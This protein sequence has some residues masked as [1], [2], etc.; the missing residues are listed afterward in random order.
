MS[1]AGIDSG[2]VRSV[3]RAL[4]LLKLI[5][6]HP[7]CG[8]HALHQ[9][10]GLP[11]P[12]VLRLLRT[13]EREGYLE[14]DGI[15][16]VYHLAAKVQELSRGYSSRALIAKIAAPIVLATTGR[17]RWPLAVGTLDDDAIVVRYSTMPYSPLAVVNTTLGH[18]H[19]LLTSAM[20]RAYLNACAT[21][22]RQRLLQ[23]L[24]ARRTPELRPELRELRRQRALGYGL[25]LARRRGESATLAVA[26]VHEREVLA[27]LSLTSFGRTMDDAFIARQLPVLQ[28]TA[29]RVVAAYRAA[30]TRETPYPPV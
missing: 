9:A 13:L 1:R 30:L 19:S 23:T 20:G 21:G 29:S 26:V 6:A 16:G 28:T 17:I 2:S 3:A 25:R 14:A 24:N 7:G 5:N 4:A 22:P 18:R 10:T 11:K 27:V 12:T 8:L 15:P